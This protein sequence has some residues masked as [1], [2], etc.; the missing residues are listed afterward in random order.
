M[1]M[2]KHTHTH[3]IYYTSV[4]LLPMLLLGCCGWVASGERVAGGELFL[5]REKRVRKN[6][7]QPSG[8]LRIIICYGKSYVS[9]SLSLSLYKNF[10]RCG[11][12]WRR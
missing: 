10:S 3:M 9:L 11:A 1:Q 12:F 8:I 6:F 4:F 5:D 7:S 2:Y